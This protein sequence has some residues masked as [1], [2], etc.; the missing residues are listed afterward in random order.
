MAEE[1][2][3]DGKEVERPA[4]EFADRGSCGTGAQPVRYRH[5]VRRPRWS[6]YTAFVLSGGGARGAL[7]VGMLRALLEYGER[8]D[9]V[10]GTSIGAWNGAWLAYSPTLAGVEALEG[11]WRRLSTARVMLGRESSNGASARAVGPMLMLSAIQRVT[12]GHPSLYSD[13]GGLSL[14]RELFGD[15]TFEELALPTYVVAANLSRGTRAIFHSGLIAPAVLASSAIPGIFPPVTIGDEVFVDGG[16]LENSS[17]DIAV[18]QGARRLFVLDVGYDMD[19]DAAGLWPGEQTLYHTRA[20]NNGQHPLAAVLERTTQV[21]SHYHLNGVLKR[22]PPGIETHVIRPARPTNGGSLDFG[23]APEWIESA[24]LTTQ[25]YLR[26]VLPREGPARAAE[27]A[28]PG[29]SQVPVPRE[30]V[31]LGDWVYTE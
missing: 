19:A 27:P 1:F 14:S 26:T 17:L 29:E 24:Y 8:P 10:V 6:G 3:S 5:G 9:V 11:I 4:T 12:Q 21:M 2:L 25:E 30:A 18:D 22:L 31:P 20:R 16:A 7:Q 28:G 13:A 23:H 15:L